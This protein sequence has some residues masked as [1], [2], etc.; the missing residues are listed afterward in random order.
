MSICRIT[1]NA[2]PGNCHGTLQVVDGGSYPSASGLRIDQ[3]FISV[4]VLRCVTSVHQVA[5]FARALGRGVSA[6]R[7]RSCLYR[8]RSQLLPQD[9]PSFADGWRPASSDARNLPVATVS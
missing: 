6:S 3:Q 8:V 2:I 5:R 4:A 9:L 1:V 7:P